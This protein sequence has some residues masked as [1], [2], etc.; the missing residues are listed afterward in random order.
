MSRLIV[1][2][3]FTGTTPCI[4]HANA[5]AKTA[6]WQNIVSAWRNS[7]V[8]RFDRSWLDELTVFTWNTK[9][10]KSL[11]EQSLDRTGCDYYK[12]GRGV[13]KWFRHQIFLTCEF[14]PQVKTKYAMA[15]DAFDAILLESP[16]RALDLFKRQ[17]G[18]KGILYT[19]ETNYWPET[20]GTKDFEETRH[21]GRF[22]YLNSGGF[23]GETEELK[24]FFA[25]MFEEAKDLTKGFGNDEQ[26]IAHRTAAK[27]IFRD[28]VHLDH[29][30]RI[31]QP[32]FGMTNREIELIS[33]D[34]VLPLTLE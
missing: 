34:S 28:A 24:C 13:Q 29:D 12:L 7:D 4:L 32:L 31:F 23:I 9:E 19:A 21:T 11:F 2:N 27:E 15:S 26:G 3:R 33:A 17:Y 20:A 16:G 5:V 6:Y 10:E 14:L 30:C 8:T 18:G 25:A 22:R 1:R